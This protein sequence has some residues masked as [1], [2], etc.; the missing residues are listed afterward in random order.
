MAGV[1]AVI[2][3]I[4]S[5]AIA[6]N[7][8]PN[9]DVDNQTSLVLLNFPK[10]VELSVLV[11][12]VSQRL[13]IN[14]IYDE[15][16]ANKR[17]TIKAPQQVPSTSLLG[18]LESA[19]HIK[20][21]TLVESAE[22]GFMRIAPTAEM[23]V[24]TK[25]TDDDG[26]APAEGTTVA[27]TQV[28]TLKHADA[29]L[30]EASLKPYLSKPG[31]NIFSLPDQDILIISDMAMNVRR[32]MQMIKLLDQPTPERQ[33]EVYTLTH[34]QSKELAQ[35]VKQIMQLKDRTRSRRGSSSSQTV[36][37]VSD[38]RTNQ[39]M[40]V[41]TP[42]QLND[43]KALIKSLDIPIPENQNPVR[44]YKLLH[45]AAEDVLATLK[46]IQGDEG[47]ETTTIQNLFDNNSPEPQSYD[48][49]QTQAPEPDTSEPT[50]QN[51]DA[52]NPNPTPAS[53]EAMIAAKR[54]PSR[55]PQPNLSKFQQSPTVKPKVAR[56]AA[57]IHTN[58]IVVVAK[59]P[60]QQ[61]YAA[62]IQELDQRRPQVLLEAT[63]VTLDTSDNFSLGVEISVDGSA[64]N[65]KIV[66]FS[67]FGLSTIDATT[68]AVTPSASTG[69][70]FALFNADVADV[71]IK[72]LKRTGR[73]KV[74]SAPKILV[75][76]NESG[77]L[78]SNAQE[79]YESVNASDTVA[80]TS[81][82]GFV[83]AGT[84]I[85]LTPHISNGDYLQLEYSIELSSFTGERIGN[86]PPPRQQNTIESKVTVPDG[87]T[88]VLGG[89][90]RTDFR[91]TIT[92][93]PILGEIPILEHLFSSQLDET[94]E[95]TLFVFIK[96]S[97]LRDDAFEDL[98]HLSEYDV[99][100]S[101]QPR[102]YPDSQ[103]VWMN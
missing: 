92:R 72:A 90:K 59:P 22:P 77:K 80:T 76:D 4:H 19:L 5:Q 32:I 46:N 8:V 97:I 23:T 60:V 99:E 88:I 100:K 17:L 49:Q 44:F 55:Q 42:D 67:S 71:V 18:L 81:F 11:E 26:K 27:V 91:K 54:P 3:G 53:E 93:I 62:L 48:Q 57:D 39:I 86:L 14:F 41:G 28:A 65:G 64:D 10:D 34:A 7:Q 74:A 50:A 98:K 96:A 73:A 87:Q 36:E 56:V 85:S 58:S 89:L 43:V 82:G 68:G 15:Q 70:N 35:K 6:Q 38:D 30:V 66:S 101:E 40:V 83:E 84:T 25:L 29:K 45:R 69:F 47:L 102:D 78:A 63:V 2:L 20:G 51:N 94:S 1:C 13:G 12:Y 9:Q 16:L 95:G 75:N 33:I 37:C 79:P 61:I 24:V 21:F 103:P 31:G 52:T